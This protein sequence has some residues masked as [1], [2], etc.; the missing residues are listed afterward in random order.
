MTILSIIVIA[1]IGEGL[2]ET[3]KMI[4]QNGK[5]SVDRVGA[6]V[7]GL[8]L[9]AGTGLDL[10]DM[11]GIPMVIP[12]IGVALTGILI[13]RGANFVHDILKSVN[14]IMSN[15]KPPKEISPTGEVTEYRY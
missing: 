15:S 1:L 6:L 14:N 2:W 12:Y 7:I 4:W 10:M 11:I 13:S 9:A 5:V 8:M 3:L